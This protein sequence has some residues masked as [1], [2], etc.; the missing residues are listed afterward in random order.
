MARRGFPRP[1]TCPQERSRRTTRTPSSSSPNAAGE[2]TYSNQV[3]LGGLTPKLHPAIAPIVCTTWLVLVAACSLPGS[4]SASPA[5]IASPEPTSL[6]CPDGQAARAGLVN[7]GAYIGTWQSTHPRDTKVPLDYELGAAPGHVGVGCSADGFVIEERIYPLNQT[8]A[9]SALRIA[10]TD[11]PDDARKI[12]DHMHAGCRT[13]QY[14]SAKLASQLGE[15]DRDGH[16][17]ITFQSEGP[18]YNP[19]SVTV[20]RID[21]VDILGADSQ[22]C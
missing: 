11:L 20:I 22:R 13:L 21:V 16:L 2:A 18:T 8:P 1:L 12:Y 14:A 19:A 5:A 15:D 6:G 10:L 3:L 4:A 7:F 17:S 9:G